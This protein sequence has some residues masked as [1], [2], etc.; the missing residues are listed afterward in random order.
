MPTY[1]ALDTTALSRRRLLQLLGLGAGT[2][3]LAACVPEAGPAAPNAAGTAAA[4]TK[5]DFSFASWSLTEE[6]AAPAIRELLGQYAG[7]NDVEVREVSY[8]Y[9]E[10]ISQLTLQVKGGQV[11]G[12]VHVDVAWLGSLAALGKLQDLGPLAQGVDYTE[13]GLSAATFDGVQYGL[14]WNIGAI[15]LIANTDLLERAGIAA[16]PT[17]VDEFESA[18][19][20]LKKLGGGVVPYAAST[21]AAQ[22][23]DVLIWMETFG[24]PLLDSG[25][26]TIGDDASVEAVTWYRSLYDQG[27]IAPDVDRFDARSLFAQGRAAIYD[28]AIVGRDAV[29]TES[30]DKKLADKLTAWSRPVLAA[31]D[32]PRALVWGGA[33]AV[34]DGEGAETAADFARWMTSDVD[35]ARQYFEARG[36]PPATESALV[37][38]DVADDAFG[39]QF[40]ERITATATTNP[41]WV[42][43]QYAQIETVIAEQVQA[44][45]VGSAEP[46]AAMEKAGAAA[47]KL[48]D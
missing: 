17:T 23:K 41:F 21:K 30:P 10:Y 39:A 26:V 19:K 8:P 25:K 27:L 3:T 14:P 1:P 5:T 43:P 4:G 38:P 40:A 42:Y 16:A 7:D 48:V 29:V 22:L 9:N 24:S 28:D 37:L 18:L 2:L 36:L 13:A 20:D 47:Q 34:V 45:L 46:R 12:A 31:G 35:V 33:I 6:S 15:G 11:A 32:T 44:V